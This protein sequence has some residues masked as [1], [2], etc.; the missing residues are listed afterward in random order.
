MLVPPEGY[1]QVYD[2]IKQDFYQSQERKVLVFVATDSCD[3]VCATKTLQVLTVS[4]CSDHA[5]DCQCLAAGLS[6]LTAQ[7]FCRPSFIEIACSSLCTLCQPIQK[8]RGCAER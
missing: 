3:S 5:L 7:L 8:S 4:H 6:Q 2:S 1:V